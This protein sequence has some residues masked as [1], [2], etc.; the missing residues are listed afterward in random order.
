MRFPPTVVYC[1]VNRQQQLLKPS[2]TSPSQGGR[3]IIRAS[4]E[5][6]RRIRHLPGGD[7]T[8]DCPEELV[9]P[10]THFKLSSWRLNNG[11]EQWLSISVWLQ[12][13]ASLPAIPR[14]LQV[15][16]EEFFLFP[17]QAVV[18]PSSRL[19]SNRV[20]NILNTYRPRATI[21]YILFS[22]PIWGGPNL[23]E[24]R[25]RSRKQ[26]I[27]YRRRPAGGANERWKS[28]PGA[29]PSDI[30]E[31]CLFEIYVQIEIVII[32]TRRCRRVL[33]DGPLR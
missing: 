8:N 1:N 19:Y 26:L 18:F 3:K 15:F 23:R 5:N 2:S 31:T 16:T 24:D 32:V 14:I 30:S 12:L 27:N 4:L 21:T 29:N 33:C 20:L 28:W 17:A 6:L 13:A 11:N 22:T 10:R 25:R 7:F 9:E